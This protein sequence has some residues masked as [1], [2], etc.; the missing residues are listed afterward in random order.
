MVK[1]KSEYIDPE[2]FKFLLDLMRPDN[3]NVVRVS[4]ITGLRVGDVLALTRANL[5]PDGRIVTVCDKTDKP[6]DG[7]ISAGF[8][9]ELL[10][11]A[12]DSDW[13]FPSP[14]PRAKGKHRTRQ[15]VWY[16]LKRVAKI[17]AVPKN[18]SPHS[19]RKIFAVDEFRKR[20]IESAQI[21][22]Q[23]DRISTTAIYAFADQLADQPSKKPRTPAEVSADVE[24]VLD[25]FY[26]AF[27][28][29]E[30]FAQCV[31]RL[32]GANLAP[33]QSAAAPDQ[34]ESR[35]TEPGEPP[36]KKRVVKKKRHP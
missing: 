12:G 22:L 25:R 30:Y 32:I 31:A 11:R 35:P 3:A 21:A 15:A 1:V 6:F 7:K 34:S 4:L 24:Q 17:C 19:A 16:D 28:G 20:G 14:S 13:I 2:Q 36:K 8:A 9:A 29:R 27:G 10:R 23:H 26:E 33:D 5:H 18:I